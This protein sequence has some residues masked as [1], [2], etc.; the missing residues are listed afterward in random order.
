MPLGY[1][2]LFAKKKPSFL[3]EGQSR[4]T[5]PRDVHRLFSRKRY[6]N[7][8]KNDAGGNYRY[9]RLEANTA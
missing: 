1:P 7:K 4:D 3:G 5:I 9:E 8:Y 2:N 6:I